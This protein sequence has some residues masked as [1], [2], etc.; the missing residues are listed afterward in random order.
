MPKVVD[1]DVRRA[2][3]VEATWR[4][5]AEGGIEGAT[6]R[7]IAEAAQCTTGRVTHYFETKDDVLV[8]ALRG[9]YRAATARMAAHLD[10][11]DPRL[12]LRAVMLEALPVD[13]ERQVEWKVWLA[14]WGRAAADAR[15]RLE[16][17]RHYVEW[18]ALLDDLLR[19]VR[20]EEPAAGR[21]TAVDLIACGIDGLGIQAVLEPGAFTQHRLERDV[22]ALIAAA[23]G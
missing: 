6:V 15:L 18:R 16:Q 4:A 7:R 19:R 1:H 23:T 5:I 20:P 8:A 17:E 13:D 14:F 11:R 21:R 3:L 10:G 12:V 22:D 9:A 2:E